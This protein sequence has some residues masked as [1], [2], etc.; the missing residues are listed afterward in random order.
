MIALDYHEM[1]RN[2]CKATGKW[3]L[4][5]EFKFGAGDEIQ[6]IFK[7]APYLKEVSSQILAEERGLLLFD[8]EEEMERYYDLTVG[9][10]GPTASNPYNG[11]A[12]V[13][14]ATCS[15]TGRFLKENT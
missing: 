15:P 14:A 1:V 13:Y 5:I 4:S 9:D 8:S 10:D 2:V 6:E 11:P 12:K 3:G 7:A